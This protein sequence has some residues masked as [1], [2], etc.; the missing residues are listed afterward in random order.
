M[1]FV[2][3]I[4]YTVGAKITSTINKKESTISV[5]QSPLIS[6]FSVS[7]CKT[8]AHYQQHSL[9]N[10]SYEPAHSH[11]CMKS[12][13]PQFCFLLML[14]RKSVSLQPVNGSLNSFGWSWSYVCAR[15]LCI[16]SLIRGNEGA[17]RDPG[18]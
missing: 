10:Y 14:L 1:H 16:R 18:F 3:A 12:L 6:L 17:L 13:F 8:A 7:Q 11:C 9:F 2:A 5:F 4:V 15:L